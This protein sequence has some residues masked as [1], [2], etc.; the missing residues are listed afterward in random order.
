MPQNVTVFGDRAFKEVIK[1]KIRSSG[2]AVTQS[3]WRPFKKGRLGHRH[4]EGRPCEDTGRRQ[5]STNQR[6]RTQE[7]QP[8]DTWISG[9]QPLKL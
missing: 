2:W 6:E 5:P 9:F 1:V 4:T 3:D 8:A 7:K